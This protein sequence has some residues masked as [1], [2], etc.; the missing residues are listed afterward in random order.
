MNRFFLLIFIIFSGLIFYQ[1]ILSKNGIIEK[2]AI[3]REK[4]KLN[5][6]IIL[7]QFEVNENNR[8]LDDLKNNPEAL[9]SLANE[10]GFF[11]D[12]VKLLKIIEDYKKPDVNAGIISDKDKEMIIKKIKENNENDIKLNKIRMWIKLIFYFVFAFFIILTLFS[13]RKNHE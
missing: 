11:N 8:Y 5:L 7:L 3:E 6:I 12:D 4:E 13:A 2:F 10:L 1:G 9:K